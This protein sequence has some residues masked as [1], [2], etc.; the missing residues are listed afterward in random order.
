MLG[1]LISLGW[2]S[3]P[4]WFDSVKHGLIE[5]FSS[6]PLEN[7]ANPVQSTRYF[8]E[9]TLLHRLGKTTEI[10]IF[11][12]GVMTIVEII[13]YFNGFSIIKGFVKRKKKVRILWI[14]SIM[15]FM[16]SAIFDNLTATIVLISIL[17]KVVK[18]RDM[19][20]WYAGLIIIAATAAG[21]WSSIGDVTTTMLWITKKVTTDHLF[22]NL[23]LPA[24]LCMAV[25]ALITAFLPIFKGNLTTN[26]N[27]LPDEKAIKVLP[28]YI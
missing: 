13:D 12:L 5:G 10:L 8:I 19:R 22:V 4:H 20:L 17:Q 21:A 2:D 24:L 23:F 1:V 27:A 16:L 15:A 25:A 26:E 28:C 3:F 14:F 11:L 9:E 7:E 18:H 6:L